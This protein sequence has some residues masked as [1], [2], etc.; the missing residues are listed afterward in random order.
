MATIREI[1]AQAKNL[2]FGGAAAATPENMSVF[3][4]IGSTGEKM[5]DDLP[6]RAADWSSRRDFL[7]SY[8]NSPSTKE[9]NA[10]S[11]YKAMF[12]AIVC[13]AL[14]V[15][16]F[17]WVNHYVAA[18]FAFLTGKYWSDRIVNYAWAVK[19]YSGR[20]LIQTV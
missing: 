15:A 11:V 4:P 16:S 9:G 12:Y 7:E 2:K 6:L 17:L 10:G 3:M 8:F 14:T 13:A 5:S 18:V 1:R 20:P 19:W